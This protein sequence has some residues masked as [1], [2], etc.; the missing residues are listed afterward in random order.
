[1]SREIVR[2]L[3]SLSSPQCR[4]L[5]VW[6]VVLG[7]GLFGLLAGV[8][9]LL[10]IEVPA[11]GGAVAEGI[12][13]APRFINPL[14][15]SSD[16]DRDLTAIIY[17]G[18]MRITS[19]GTPKPDLAESYTVS[20]DGL[21]YTFVLKHGLRWHDGEPLIADD[22]SFTI[23]GAQDPLLK[24][25]KRAAWD[26]V[27]VIKQDDR[28]IIFNLKQAYPSFL[29]N[30][31]MGI[32]PKHIWSQ[33]ETET[34]PLSKFNLE[35]IGSGPYQISG[36]KKNKLGI[37][38]YY[39]L[40]AFSNFAL[41]Q[42]KIK[43]W[44]L[45]FYPNEAELV[46]AY[47]HGDIQSLSAISAE[48][49]AALEAGGARFIKSPLPK[50]FAVFLNQN[51]APVLA[52]KEVRQAL[53]LAVDK[54]VII[55]TVLHGYGSITRGPLPSIAANT[56]TS[57]SGIESAKN[58][59]TKNGWVWNEVKKQWEK[60]I[61][62]GKTTSTII[63]AL[64]LATSNTPE[65]EQTASLIK[66]DW[67]KLGAKVDLKIYEVGDLN[68]NII[69]PRQ[70]DAL[71]FG[72]I[73]GR[74]L[75]LFPFWHSSQRLD[76]GLNIALYANTNA[77]KLL[78]ETRALSNPAKIAAG[79]ERLQTIIAGDLPAIFI[80]SPYFLYAIPAAMKNVALVPITTASDRFAT[81]NEWYL[82]TDRVWP[83]FVK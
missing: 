5:A 11:R 82:T 37:P 32:L 49:A 66:N 27:K 79:N 54:N 20:P 30:A 38:E 15:A 47:R 14:L 53:D 52:N 57:T 83:L 28:T 76:P 16:T 39:D 61:T 25:A 17:S 50:I 10:T 12:V 1:M 6:L 19:D 43:K 55:T 4:W 9:Q 68:Q 72:E 42:P 45:N 56:A 2:V 18:L 26:G 48:S 29:E 62:K 46:A 75:D 7:V 34:F 74:R 23:E 36:I 77:D 3:G 65:L 67:E 33:V 31:T 58:V 35:S 59:L 69:R 8:S 73:L 41:G 81:M 71:F 60:K 63:L 51:R 44:R 24:S 80:Y 64:S 21:T 78:E 40:T 13:G 22:V 70:Y